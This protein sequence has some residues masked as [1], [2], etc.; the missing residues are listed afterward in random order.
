[1]IMLR[2]ALRRGTRTGKRTEVNVEV[3]KIRLEFRSKSDYNAHVNEVV[4]NIEEII[5]N[6][7]DV[8]YEDECRYVTFKARQ[9]H[10]MIKEKQ[11]I[12][13]LL[14]QW[15]NQLKHKIIGKKFRI[16]TKLDC[17]NS[18]ICIELV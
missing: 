18:M 13:Q 17:Q 5:R 3:K 16:S 2:G 7:Y 9:K 8:Y 4:K 12:E 15:R 14:K 11:Q 10:F 1:M 6:N